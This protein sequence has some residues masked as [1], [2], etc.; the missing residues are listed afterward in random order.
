MHRQG[1]AQADATFVRAQVKK[2][3]TSAHLPLTSHRRLS[4]RPLDGLGNR[5]LLV[6]HAHVWA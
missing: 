2:W 5:Q 6:E 3:I 4:R 1:F